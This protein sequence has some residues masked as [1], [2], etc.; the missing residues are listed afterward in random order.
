[1]LALCYS[2]VPLSYD[3]MYKTKIYNT[4]IL[5]LEQLNDT[6]PSFILLFTADFLTVT[7]QSDFCKHILSFLIKI[8]WLGII[9]HKIF[10]SVIDLWYIIG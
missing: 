5:T 10:E 1:M 3:S 6:Q 9:S 4:R 8:I 7:C 2:G